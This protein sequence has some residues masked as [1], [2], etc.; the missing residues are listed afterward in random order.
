MDAIFKII[1]DK[2]IKK[3]VLKLEKWQSDALD[4]IKFL[5]DGIKYKSSIFKCYKNNSFIAQKCLDDCKE[6]NKPYSLYFIKLYN[7][8]KKG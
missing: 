3:G 5:N 2:N 6:L 7:L 4:T 8:K 1:E